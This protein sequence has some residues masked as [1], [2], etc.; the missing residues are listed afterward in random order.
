MTA[1]LARFDA[2]ACVLGELVGTVAGYRFD[3]PY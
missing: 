3:P 2:R 1:P